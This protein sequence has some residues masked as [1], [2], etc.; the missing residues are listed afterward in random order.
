MTMETRARSPKGGYL[1]QWLRRPARMV[2]EQ[3]LR[4]AAFGVGSGAVSLLFLW[5]RARY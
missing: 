4:G 5:F 1:R 2:R 3:M